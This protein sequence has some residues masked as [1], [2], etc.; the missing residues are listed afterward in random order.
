MKKLFNTPFSIIVFTVVFIVSLFVLPEH[1]RTGQYFWLGV[2]FIT[3]FSLNMTCIVKTMR[4]RAKIAKAQ[5]AGVVG[6]IATAV[7]FTA[8]QMCGVGGPLC[9]ALFGSIAFASI[10]PA[11]SLHYFTSY[12][13]YIVVGAIVVQ[14]VS[15]WYLGCLKK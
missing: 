6:I 12:A 10:L 3:L 1:I 14:I 13:V 2:L 4:E 5:G 15:L 9:G 8:L 11:G 7:G